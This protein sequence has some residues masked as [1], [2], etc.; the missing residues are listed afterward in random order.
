M[1]KLLGIVILGLL[2]STSVN[3]AKVKVKEKGSN[4]IIIKEKRGSRNNDA[5]LMPGVAEIVNNYCAS[6]NLIG[7]YILAKYNYVGAPFGPRPS[8]GTIL[9]DAKGPLT[10][11]KYR[12]FCASSHID[13]LRLFHSDNK[14]KSKIKIYPGTGNA[15]K[16]Y[17]V[18][19]NEIL[20]D[21]F[22]K[23]TNQ[24]YAKK[25]EDEKRKKEEEKQRIAEEK[26]KK[27]EEKR[28][29][30]K[31]KEKE[32]YSTLPGKQFN[33][34]GCNNNS[35]SSASF[36]IN[37]NTQTV[38]AKIDFTN[39]NR[40]TIG[41]FRIKEINNKTI[42]TNKIKLSQ[43][44]S[45]SNYKDY[46]YEA[47]KATTVELKIDVQSKTVLDEWKAIYP[48]TNNRQLKKGY[49][50]M[51]QIKNKRILS[52]NWNCYNLAV[53]DKQEEPKTAEKPK[54]K[55][56]EKSTNDEKIYSVGSGT[57]FFINRSGH[58][59]SNNHVID[60]CNAVKLH[61]KGKVTPVTIL[62]TDR[63]NDLSLMKV[64]TKPDDVFPVAIDDANLLDDVYVAGF[65]FGKDVS[66]S[67]K[68]TKGVVSALTGIANNYS[69]IQIDAALQP[70]NSGGPIINNEGNVVG[71]AVAKLDY[72]IILENYDTIP[73]GTNFGIKSSTVQQ[74][75]KANNVKSIQP[76]RREMS[77][78]DIGAKIQKATVYLDCFMTA[79]RYEKL[80][81]KKVMYKNI[82]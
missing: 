55:Q 37:L 56:T 75:I 62:A 66:S 52:V 10:S 29:A 72:K 38:V 33:L 78:K 71:V 40:I 32:K 7:F 47:I 4:Y 65:P 19:K 43:Y 28:K 25:I 34:D 20:G 22:V 9:Q 67:V 59:V 16:L 63:S 5:R 6:K 64:D 11:H 80:K 49:D 50:E 46:V 54:K 68:V 23:T 57:G 45:G 14:I 51:F 2:L 12:Y 1:K 70:G 15:Y 13:A 42:S 53:L 69:N 73:E 81:S 74:F 44:F 36:Q 39:D 58:I 18:Q 48:N 77:T 61:Y 31:P 76:N 82:E 17:L 35:N 3:A 30:E 79:Q 26:R 60:S 24:L 21:Y 27:E 41:N 8:T